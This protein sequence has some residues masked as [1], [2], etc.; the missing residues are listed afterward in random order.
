MATANITNTMATMTRPTQTEKKR[1]LIDAAESQERALKKRPTIHAFATPV[2][3]TLTTI[4]AYNKVDSKQRRVL[5]VLQSST[6]PAWQDSLSALT[7]PSRLA[8]ICIRGF[9]LQRAFIFKFINSTHANAQ[10]RLRCGRQ[11]K[12]RLYATLY[13]SCVGFC[14]CSAHPLCAN[15]NSPP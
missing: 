7:A 3:A 10:L 6:R 12:S 9:R 8:E 15:T 2:A 13:S 1:K 4:N 14:P 11:S 5:G